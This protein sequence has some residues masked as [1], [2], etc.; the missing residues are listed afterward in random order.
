MVESCSILSASGEA[1]PRNAET[2][3]FWWTFP[4]LRVSEQDLEKNQVFPAIQRLLMT[5]FGFNSDWMFVEGPESWTPKDYAVCTPPGGSPTLFTLVQVPGWKRI[6]EEMRSEWWDVRTE[7]TVAKYRNYRWFSA[8][9]P[10]EENA[11]F[12][13]VG[14]QVIKDLLKVPLRFIALPLADYAQQLQYA[15]GLSQLEVFWI[16]SLLE[17]CRRVDNDDFNT[18]RK[19]VVGTAFQVSQE[20]KQR[21]P[22]NTSVFSFKLLECGSQSHP[23]ASDYQGRIRDAIILPTASRIEAGPL[24]GLSWKF[25]RLL[26]PS[27]FWIQTFGRGPPSRNFLSHEECC[28]AWRAPGLSKGRAPRSSIEFLKFE[29]SSDSKFSFSAV[30]N[31]IYDVFQGRILEGDDS[32]IDLSPVHSPESV[33]APQDSSR[34]PLTLQQGLAPVLNELVNAAEDLMSFDVATSSDL[35]L[36]EH[37]RRLVRTIGSEEAKLQFV[38]KEVDRQ[39]QEHEFH[40]SNPLCAV[41]GEGQHWARECPQVPL[42]QRQPGSRNSGEPPSGVVHPSQGQ[43]R[44]KKKKKRQT[45]Q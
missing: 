8:S 45:S 22:R 13:K 16:G 10:F 23:L 2:P 15:P 42:A 37:C 11:H 21:E 41:C 24:V 39:T 3:L 17:T 34:E 28:W 25:G 4:W 7:A 35:E 36:A 20:R 40:Q 32:R 31:H 30:M 14:I 43:G 5:T 9:F 6:M 38:Q 26:M 33:S 44:T 29:E 12:S 18:F 1:V 19:L 27:N